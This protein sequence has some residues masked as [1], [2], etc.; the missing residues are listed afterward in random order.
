MN[1][2]GHHWTGSGQG[3]PGTATD[4]AA[5]PVIELEQPFTASDLYA[6]RAAVVAHADA[7]GLPQPVIDALLIVAG[8][9][10]SNVVLHGG[11]TGRLHLSRAG[12]DVVCEVSDQGP[13]IADPEQVGRV[14]VPP[15]ALSG[16]GLWMVR[17][18]SRRV[19]VAAGPH[20]TTV[21]A[22][23]ETTPDVTA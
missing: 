7:A 5:E 9:L 8:E 17:Q 20:G 19:E 21:T 1:G 18:L 4:R 12:G 6:L 2:T 11:G 23:L 3:A 16:R 14:P 15:S 10:C 13:G 22:T